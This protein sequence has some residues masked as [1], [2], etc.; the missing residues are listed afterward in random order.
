MKEIP[1]KNCLN[2]KKS[3]KK[4]NNQMSLYIKKEKEKVKGKEKERKSILRGKCPIHVR[5]GQ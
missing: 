4:G 2:N 5:Q 1:N 3:R